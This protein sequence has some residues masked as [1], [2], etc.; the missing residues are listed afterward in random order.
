MPEI[1]VDAPAGSVIITP[2]EMY[3]TVVATREAVQRLE[4]LVDPALNSIREDVEKQNDRLEGME[5]RIGALE[6]WRWGVIAAAGTGLIG[7]GL[8]LGQIFNT[9]TGG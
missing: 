5:A 2:S 9:V 7:G 8:G 6:R 3:A 4:T 1:H